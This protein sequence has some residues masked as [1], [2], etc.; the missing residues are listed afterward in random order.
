M[1]Y[2]AH[3][4]DDR[5]APAEFAGAASRTGYSPPGPRN[6]RGGRVIFHGFV[7][8]GGGSTR[9][10]TDKALVQL[11]GKTML[12]R[13]GELL[14]SVCHHVTIVAAA[15]KYAD[16]PWPM[17]ADRWPGQGPLG[18]ILT[19]LHRLGETGSADL[20]RDLERDPFSFPF[21]LSCHRPF[22]TKDF[23]RFLT[24]RA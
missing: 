17:I 5:P 4:G 18:G 10:G 1:E 22:L 23:R 9:F 14:A 7:Q 6:S 16:A 8:A 2:F 21:V 24:G 3:G 11:E 12:Q 13:T 15:G 19:A 20:T